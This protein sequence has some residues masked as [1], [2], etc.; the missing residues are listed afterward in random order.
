[1]GPRGEHLVPREVS[2]Q[3]QERGHAVHGADRPRGDRP[4][5]VVRG[6]GAG[7]CIDSRSCAS[8]E[9]HTDRTT[10][11]FRIVIAWDDERKS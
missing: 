5:E 10:D 6:A 4:E 11:N 9:Q 1:M 3:G 2:F 8:A 7:L